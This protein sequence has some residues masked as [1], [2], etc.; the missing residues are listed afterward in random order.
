MK[1]LR[2][3]VHHSPRT[4]H[5]MQ[6][7]VLEQP[8]IGAYH[9]LQGN[10]TGADIW[11]SLFYIEADRESY[12][13]ALEQTSRV[14]EYELIPVGE[15]AFYAYLREQTADPDKEIYAAF[16]YPTLVVIPPI[17]Y[18]TQGTMRITVI[19]DS[20]ELQAAIE[21]LPSD[22]SVEIDQIQEFV[23]PQPAVAA[24]LSARQ[25]EALDVAFGMGYYEIPRQ[26]TVD[27]IAD[28]LDCAPGT[29]AEHIQKAEVKL[30]RQV[31]E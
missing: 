7:H 15:R 6:E 1:C 16:T 24:V 9:L 11:T 10:M 26:T 13:T 2:L 25:S 5:P 8:A 23:G 4:M 12:A 27:E 29:A 31:L 28:R 21:A 19:G 14:V 22:M 3:T 20:A 17:E 18:T 30:M